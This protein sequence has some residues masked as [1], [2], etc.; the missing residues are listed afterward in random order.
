MLMMV[1]LALMAEVQPVININGQDAKTVMSEIT[2]TAEQVVIRYEDGTTVTL[3]NSDMIVL[4]FVEKNPSTEMN[5]VFNTFSLDGFVG[6]EL[7]ISGIEN[8]TPIAIYSLD[9]RVMK[10]TRFV[11]G[12]AVS[13]AGIPAGVYI[14]SAGGNIVKFMKH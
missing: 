3:G 12:Q 4:N 2:F 11:A 10:S 13:V 5:S 14:L 9:G 6:D 8:N 7:R 1:S